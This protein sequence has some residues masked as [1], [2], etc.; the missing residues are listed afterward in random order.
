MID[1]SDYRF[2]YKINMYACT[3]HIIKA[4]QIK[5]EAVCQFLNDAST[6]ST[7]QLKL[8]WYCVVL[9]ANKHRMIITWEE[10]V[11]DLLQHICHSMTS[12]RVEVRLGK[13]MEIE[14]KLHI[15]PHLLLESDA[16]ECTFCSQT[17]PRERTQT[18]TTEGGHDSLAKYYFPPKNMTVYNHGS[19]ENWSQDPRLVYKRIIFD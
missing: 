16:G 10:L 7:F 14:W 4:N 5:L 2:I 18:G 1:I 11:Q 15:A 13:L 8:D 12:A 3:L 9:D 6:I 19:V 17:Q